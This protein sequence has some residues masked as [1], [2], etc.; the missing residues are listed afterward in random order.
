M[1][2]KLEPVD[3]QVKWLSAKAKTEFCISSMKSAKRGKA[4]LFFAK[5]AILKPAHMKKADTFQDRLLSNRFKPGRYFTAGAGFAASWKAAYMST[6]PPVTLS[7]ENFV[8]FF[9]SPGM[10]TFFFAIDL[11]LDCMMMERIS[12]GVRL[13]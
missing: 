1:G 5:T 11:S 9:F 2:S 10:I 7:F 6:I 4:A 12:A 13:G 3:R 8:F